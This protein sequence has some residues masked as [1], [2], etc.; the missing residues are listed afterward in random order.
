MVNLHALQ[1]EKLSV[2]AIFQKL[3]SIG[4]KTDRG[5][6][7]FRP[8][9]LQNPI[10]VSNFESSLFPENRLRGIKTGPT[11]TASACRK[12]QELPDQDK[13]NRGTLSAHKIKPGR[14]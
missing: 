11:K 13:R 6:V 2:I 1:P 12:P 10:P 4:N 14:H 9:M 5:G 7:I 3:S 8:F